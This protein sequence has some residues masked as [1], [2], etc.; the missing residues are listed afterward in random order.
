MARRTVI[1]RS[2]TNSTFGALESLHY[3]R[4]LLITRAGNHSMAPA[5]PCTYACA[6]L[7]ESDF[8]CMHGSVV[9]GDWGCTAGRY[10]THT[11]GEHAAMRGSVANVA[12]VTWLSSNTEKKNK[13][14]FGTISSIP[15]RW[16]H[17]EKPSSPRLTL[18]QQGRMAAFHNFLECVNIFH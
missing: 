17:G 6:Q 3:L 4:A 15:A 7:R 5:I 13:K 11:H 18:S 14:Y 8:L 16:S 12:M 1:P 2:C 10:Y 9:N